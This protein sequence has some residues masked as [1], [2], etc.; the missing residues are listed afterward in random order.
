M[1]AYLQL[2]RPPS[3]EGTTSPAPHFDIVAR[4][5]FVLAGFGL[6]FILLA[7]WALKLE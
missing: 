4:A 5:C 3:E 6:G 7:W 2:L 1:D